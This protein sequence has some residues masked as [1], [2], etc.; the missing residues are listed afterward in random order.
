MNYP[1]S[2]ITA[3]NLAARSKALATRFSCPQCGMANS[4]VEYHGWYCRNTEC[5][6]AEG[7]KPLQLSRPAP[8]ILRDQRASRPARRISTVRILFTRTATRR[9]RR[10]ILTKTPQRIRG[11]RRPG[12]LLAL[13]ELS[14]E[15]GEVT[16]AMTRRFELKAEETELLDAEMFNLV[17]RDGEPTLLRHAP[18]PDASTPPC[19]RGCRGSRSTDERRPVCI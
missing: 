2:P 14:P 10:W 3:A 1:E 9:R 4:T 15:H 19:I 16:K 5:R 13:C 7:N 17:G 11:F 12:K 6:D 18:Q 8:G